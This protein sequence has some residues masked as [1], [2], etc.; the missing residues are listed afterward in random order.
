MRIALMSI[1]GLESRPYQPD[2]RESV[3]PEDQHRSANDKAKSLVGGTTS[4]L[5]HTEE[6]E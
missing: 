3:I 2:W 5:R 1:F 6:I 4:T